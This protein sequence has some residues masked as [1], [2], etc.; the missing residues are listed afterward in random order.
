MNT[1]KRN[2]I[3]IGS[4]IIGLILIIGI[5]SSM[6]RG[7]APSVN[8]PKEANKIVKHAEMDKELKSEKE[9]SAGDVYLKPDVAVANI[10]VKENITKEQAKVLAEK[11]AEE[12]KDQYEELSVIVDVKQGD[13]DLIK[14][15]IPATE[16]QLAAEAKVF[17]GV[18]YVKVDFKEFLGKDIT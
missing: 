13:K 7:A 12:L 10:T 17:M 18:E 16:D 14:D 9:V 2:K 4:S 15:M 11:Y 8:P 5:V 3:I 6:I 1:A